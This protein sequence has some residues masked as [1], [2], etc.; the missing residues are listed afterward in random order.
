MVIDELVERLR[1]KKFTRRT[2]TGKRNVV[3]ANPDGPEAADALEAMKEALVEAKAVIEAE[4]E[5][6]VDCNTIL[7]K[8][9]PDFGKVTDPDAL[10]EIAKYDSVLAKI[11]ATLNQG[12]PGDVNQ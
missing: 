6:S 11:D 1:R 4:R 8:G 2:I 10:E 12:V 7:Y 5:V 3:L 9:N